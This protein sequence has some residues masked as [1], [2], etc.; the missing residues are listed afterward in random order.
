MKGGGEADGQENREKKGCNEC[1]F[2]FFFTRTFE[3]VRKFTYECMCGNACLNFSHVCV[4][5]RNVSQ[6][7]KPFIYYRYL[8]CIY[9]PRD[10][11]G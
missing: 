3:R 7:F 5:M 6:I 11:E 1:M 10:H 9:L 4:W 8:S 2:V